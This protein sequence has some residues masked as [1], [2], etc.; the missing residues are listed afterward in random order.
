MTFKRVER[1]CSNCKHWHPPGDPLF[2]IRADC[3]RRAPVL[4]AKDQQPTEGFSSWEETRQWP[5]TRP[6]E[7]CGDHEFALG[8]PSR[9]IVP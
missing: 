6:A 8:K 3:R 2:A 9:K 7:V 5:K 4:L 1:A